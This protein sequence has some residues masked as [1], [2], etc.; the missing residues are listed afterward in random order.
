MSGKAPPFSTWHARALSL[1]VVA[2]GLLWV[3]VLVFDFAESRE[4]GP[5]GTVTQP[6]AARIE[7]PR[8]PVA[9]NARVAVETVGSERAPKVGC[10]HLLL[11]VGPEHVLSPE[12][13]P[14]DLV[15]LGAYGIATRG[16]EDMLRHEAAVQLGRL[17]SAAADDGEEVLVA[18]GYRSYW[19][20]AGTFAWFKDAY[21]EEAGRLSVP[22]GQSEH[23][24]GTAVDFTSAEAGY[25]LVAEFSRTSAGEWL[26]DNA[27]RFGF[28]LSY[29][30]EQETGTGVGFEPWHYRYA[31]ID[32]ARKIEAAGGSVSDFEYLEGEPHCYER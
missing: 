32:N 25:E 9:N 21:G 20:Q 28:I 6:R 30:E 5:V 23:Q 1:A 8:P 7:A 10:E 27:A 24:L 26:A 4:D 13:V 16:S 19:E 18:S 22:P 11:K 15:N 2:A 3:S 17:I 29:G 31:G 14:P 12:Y